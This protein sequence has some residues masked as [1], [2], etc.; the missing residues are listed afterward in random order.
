MWTPEGVPKWNGPLQRPST[1]VIQDDHRGHAAAALK[2]VGAFARSAGI[3][4][5]RIRWDQPKTNPSSGNMPAKLGRTIVATHKTCKAQVR[6]SA[7]SSHAA[8]P[9]MAS[10]RAQ[11]GGG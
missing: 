10:R 3:D 4:W 9:R 2:V 5:L 8:P 11:K 7:S 6:S 1:A